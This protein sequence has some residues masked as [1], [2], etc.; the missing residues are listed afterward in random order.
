MCVFSSC[1]FSS[2]PSLALLLH[3]WFSSSLF[4]LVSLH[5]S[6]SFSFSHILL[7][8]FRSLLYPCRSLLGPL[9]SGAPDTLCTLSTTAPATA[10]PPLA[11]LGKVL[12]ASVMPQAPSF[13]PSL[14]PSLPPA[15]PSKLHTFSPQFISFSTSTLPQLCHTPHLSLPPPPFP[16]NSLLPS[17]S[18]PPDQKSIPPPPPSP[19]PGGGNATRTEI[20]PSFK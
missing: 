15:L 16:P 2:F 5:A 9:I 19:T 13:P 18:P 1:P 4:L 6:S 14:L 17:F 3:P 11:G 8:L 12:M 20:P 10:P 7:S